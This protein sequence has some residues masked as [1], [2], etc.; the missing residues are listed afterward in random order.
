MDFLQCLGQGKAIED[1]DGEA[2]PDRHE[3]SSYQHHQEAGP[4]GIVV[5]ILGSLSE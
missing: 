5:E 4:G 2:D 3:K 1:L